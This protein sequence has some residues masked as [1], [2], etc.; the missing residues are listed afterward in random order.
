MNEWCQIMKVGAP[1]SNQ[2]T[3][4]PCSLMSDQ[5]ILRT[6][7]WLYLS[8]LIHVSIGFLGLRYTLIDSQKP[9]ESNG[10]DSF[11]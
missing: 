8:D 4:Q 1:E 2:P 10:V 7:F 6:V 9:K 11:L 3:N 5:N